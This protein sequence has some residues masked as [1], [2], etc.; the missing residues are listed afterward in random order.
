MPAGSDLVAFYDLWF[1]H[2]PGEL[3]VIRGGAVVHG[4][5]ATAP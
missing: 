5:P 3:V 1:E 2:G 4:T